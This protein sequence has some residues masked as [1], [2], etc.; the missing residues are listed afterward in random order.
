MKRFILLAVVLGAAGT[1][2]YYAVTGRLPWV[3]LS[4]EEQKV[5]VLREEFNRIRQ[6]WQ[7]AGKAQTFG[8]DMSSL[9]EGPLAQVAEL[10]RSLAD[11]TPQLKTAEARNQA[12]SLRRDLAAFRNSMR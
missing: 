1:G 4:E 2:G 5:V 7:Q 6:Q 8:V 3:F 12:G 11:L 9:A 10:D